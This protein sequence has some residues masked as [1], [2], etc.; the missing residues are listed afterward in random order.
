MGFWEEIPLCEG[1]TALDPWKCP[2]QM[3]LE[4]LGIVRVSPCC[5]WRWNWMIFNILPTQTIPWLHEAPVGTGSCWSPMGCGEDPPRPDLDFLVY[6]GTLKGVPGLG[7]DEFLQG[8]EQIAAPLSPGA[9]TA[10]AGTEPGRVPSAAAKSCC[11]HGN[12][13]TFLTFPRIFH[14]L[15]VGAARRAQPGLH[16][17]WRSFWAGREIIGASHLVGKIPPFGNLGSFGETG[18]GRN[19]WARV[20]AG[21][22]GREA[23]QRKRIP[24]HLLP[25]GYTSFWNDCIS[26]GLR[27]GILIEL[28]L[29]GRIRLEPLSLRKKRLLE[30]KVRLLEEPWQALCSAQ[31]ECRSRICSLGPH[32]PAAP[33]RCC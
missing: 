11:A 15:V 29:R 18:A 25:Q 3:G 20:Q 21:Q 24:S 9:S 1:G 17:V 12:Y 2:R 22:E 8:E 16:S 5:D 13:P 10:S 31:P 6:P 32:I 19:S 4:H 26:S 14:T 33:C 28:A 30:R 7:G 23:E 27:G